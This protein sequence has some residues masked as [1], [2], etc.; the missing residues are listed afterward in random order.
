MRTLLHF[1]IF[2]KFK[3][4]LNDKIEPKNTSETSNRKTLY[5][6]DHYVSY[7]S[8]W[9]PLHNVLVQDE[10]AEYAG[11][12]AVEKNYISESPIFIFGSDI[13]FTNDYPEDYNRR[14]LDACE[15][16]FPAMKEIRSHETLENLYQKINHSDLQEV[17]EFRKIK[18]RIPEIII[19]PVLEMGDPAYGE[20]NCEQDVPYEVVLRRKH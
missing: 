15:K 10:E 8:N 4:S 12:I 9:K 7:P 19:Y 20:F 2:N 1:P 18:Y 11:I 6:R 5:L 14:L 3:N 16:V 13:K 17:E